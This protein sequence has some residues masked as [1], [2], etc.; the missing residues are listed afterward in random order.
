MLYYG[1]CLSVYPAHTQLSGPGS[2]SVIILVVFRMLW[3]EVLVFI[4]W[5]LLF[6]P[7]MAPPPPLLVPLFEDGSVPVPIIRGPRKGLLDPPPDD[8]EDDEDIWFVA[9]L[10]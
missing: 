9:V 10:L 4:A 8:G 2:E 5:K 1:Q 7:F 6:V 3:F